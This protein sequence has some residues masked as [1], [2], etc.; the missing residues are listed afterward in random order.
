MVANVV[1]FGARTSI[2][3]EAMGWLVRMDSD[4]PL[5]PTEQEALKEWMSCSLLHRNEL[6][7]LSKFWS[8]ANILTGLITGLEFRRAGRR[9]SHHRAGWVG[10]ILMATSAMFASIALVYLGLQS[11]GDTTTL[12]HSTPVGQQDTI[13]LSDGS[14][15]QL[16]TDSQI[17]VTYGIDSRRVRLLRGEALFS[18]M[19]DTRRV[20]EVCV[21]DSI[22]RAI[23][24][25]FVVQL[26][27][28]Q[29]DITV[30]KGRVDVL[31]VTKAQAGIGG[32]SNKSTPLISQL[33]QL[34]AGEATHFES[35][36]G[37][38]KA[39]QLTE[40]QL[41]RRMAWRE[42]YL[43]FDGEHLSK[44]VVELNRYSKKHFEIGDSKLKSIAVGGRFRIGDMAGVLEVLHTGFGIRAIQ[45]NE[46]R[47]RLESESENGPA[48]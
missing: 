40:A 30:T 26:D 13:Q 4:D 25:A 14:Y 44:V 17:E 31:D 24:T 20:F 27:G 33:G 42:G 41:Q 39:R 10:M 22:V 47:I 28:R 29:V 7:R 3:H 9:G 16:N 45:V 8:Q 32:T 46:Y 34:T 1:K 15:V 2:E 19:P 38:I 18:V 36:S 11:L 12:T 21:A 43:A 48:Q 35:G 23:G 5:S 6:V 37:H